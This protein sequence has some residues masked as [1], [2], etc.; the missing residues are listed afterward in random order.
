MQDKGKPGNGGIVQKASFGNF[1]QVRNSY[2]KTNF[3]D[4][5]ICS[6]LDPAQEISGNANM[7]YGQQAWR[8]LEGD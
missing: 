3:C 7:N 1:D 5:R 8:D 2:F 6:Q 4:V